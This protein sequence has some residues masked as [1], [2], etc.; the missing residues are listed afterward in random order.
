[1][2]YYDFRRR[3][4]RQQCIDQLTSTFVNEAPFY[5]TMKRWY[6]EFNRGCHSLTDEFRKGRQKSVVEP[7]NINTVQK[8]IM[9]DRHV[10]YCEIKA[11]LHPENSFF[12]SKKHFFDIRSKKE[13]L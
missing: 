5:A 7:E 12:E 1:M 3:L 2:I 9:Q 11:T 13:F 10:T 8:L 6:N 4:S